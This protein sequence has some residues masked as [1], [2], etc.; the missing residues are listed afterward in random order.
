VIAR[1]RSEKL[2][3]GTKDMKKIVPINFN[4]E[5]IKAILGHTLQNDT[6]K[7]WWRENSYQSR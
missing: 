5:H 7:G 3:D 2:G 4:S 1:Y 6:G